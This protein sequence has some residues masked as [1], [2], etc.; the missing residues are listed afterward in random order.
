[1]DILCSTTHWL[2]SILGRGSL[3]RKLLLSHLATGSSTTSIRRNGYPKHWD[4]GPIM[5]MYSSRSLLLRHALQSSS[6]RRITRMS[7]ERET[8]I[9]S[10]VV[11]SPRIL[12]PLRYMAGQLTQLILNL[13]LAHAEAE[14]EISIPAALWELADSVSRL[15]IAWIY[16]QRCHQEEFYHQKIKI[17]QS[18]LRLH[19]LDLSHLGAL[20]LVL[21][22]RCS[23]IALLT[24]C[25]ALD[26][27]AK[28]GHATLTNSLFR[29]QVPRILKDWLIK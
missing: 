4:Q 16:P 6:F 15:E 11:Y 26:L 17:C 18:N 3:R 19:R 5:M 25:K 7:M 14:G 22:W 8:P 10:M 1:M 20:T 28:R 24:S 13:S 9:I 2:S 27:S 12:M 21:E 23:R 29:S